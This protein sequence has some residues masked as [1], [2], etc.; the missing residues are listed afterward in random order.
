[1]RLQKVRPCVPS[2]RRRRR[3]RAHRSRDVLVRLRG[4]DGA[5]TGVLVTHQHGD[6]VDVARL[7]VLLDANPDAP[8]YCDEGTVAALAATDVAAEIV[9]DRDM[10]DVG[11]PVRVVG[12][13][14]ASIHPDVPGDPQCRLS[15]GRSTLHPGDSLTEPAGGVEIL[16]VPT[17][18]PWL[19]SAEA[20]DYM[21]RVRP[22]LKSFRFTR[23]YS[24]TRRCT[25]AC[26][27]GSRRQA[28]RSESSSARAQST[29]NPARPRAR[30]SRRPPA[31]ADG[32]LRC[33]IQSGQMLDVRGLAATED[34]AST[35][36]THSQC[37]TGIVSPRRRSERKAR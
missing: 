24:P 8:L 10:I 26:S 28:P 27:S 35:E 11:V 16:A 5:G 17:A 33:F 31:P 7:P 37:S 12:R 20:V 9:H 1:M 21:R 18:A 2:R 3:T 22:R 32:L 30:A 25:T 4:I 19:K 14:H 34:L 29:C 15:G 23:P 6:H 13:E 36:V